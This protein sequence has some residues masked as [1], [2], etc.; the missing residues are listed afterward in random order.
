M[1][2]L[3]LLI[4]MVPWCLHATIGSAWIQS[5]AAA[6]G[7][8]EKWEEA[9]VQMNQLMV[10][11]PD[12]PDLLYDS[13]VAAYRLSEFAKAAAYF[14]NVTKVPHV[15]H[16]LKKRAHFNWGNT[17]VAL[18]KL[19][20]AVTQYQQ[21]LLMEPDNKPAEHNLKKVKEMMKQ[22]EQKEQQQ[23][24]QEQSEKNKQ[25]KNNQSKNEQNDESSQDQD[26]QNGSDNQQN[27]QRSSKKDDKGAAN[28][29]GNQ[30]KKEDAN[31]Q[32]EREQE[33]KSNDKSSQQDRNQKQN[34]LRDSHDSSSEKQ[35]K[36]QAQKQRSKDKDQP[37][38]NGSK[39]QATQKGELEDTQNDRFQEQQAVE[40][41]FGSN[42]KWMA[43]LLA[44]QEKADKAAQKVLIKTNINKQLAGHDGQNC[45]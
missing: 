3:L 43:R 18:N 26:A 20:D 45:W 13:G 25:D 14:E 35:T 42:E 24:K 39:E 8:Q 17:N 31:D 44:N 6:Y 5:K 33:G 11:S 9:Q 34:K 40:Q 10:D 12:Q 22:Q 15:E 30:E 27:Q 23:K 2:R 7:Q 4:G 1:K 37:T 36:E 28:S 41:Q 21:V 32:Q 19:A 38:K 29:S 16:D